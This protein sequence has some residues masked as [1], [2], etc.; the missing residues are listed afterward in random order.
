[1]NKTKLNAPF[2]KV[3][4]LVL[5]GLMVFSPLSVKAEVYQSPRKADFTETIDLIANPVTDNNT[6][7]MLRLSFQNAEILNFYPKNIVALPASENQKFIENNQLLVDFAQVEPF[8]KG[9]VLGQIVVKW[10][11][12]LGNA[13]IIQNDDNGYYDG[14]TANYVTGNLESHTIVNDL[15]SESA[16]ASRTIALVFISIGTVLIVTGAVLLISKKKK[17]TD[18]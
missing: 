1:M 9:D 5:L 13:A 11:S 17:K 8:K 6:V 14:E 15:A 12:N 10:G 4:G 2:V 3:L 18:E 7:M 16:I